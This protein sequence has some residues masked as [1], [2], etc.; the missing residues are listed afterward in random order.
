MVSLSLRFGTGPNSQSTQFRSEHEKKQGGRQTQGVCP[1][2][3]R[4]EGAGDCSSEC[5]RHRCG[6]QRALGGSK[7]WV[8]VSP[9]RDPEPVRSFGC[10]TADLRAMAQWLV[11]RGVGS[12]ALQSTGVY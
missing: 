12:V 7:H 5:R 10:L 11:E 3:S 4:L 9:E 8:A 6:R 1:T 2:E